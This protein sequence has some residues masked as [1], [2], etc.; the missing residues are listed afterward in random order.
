MRKTLLAAAVGLCFATGAR[1]QVGPGLVVPPAA[2]AVARASADSAMSAATNAHAHAELSYQWATNAWA[3]VVLAAPAW[4]AAT[5][6]ATAITLTN[7]LERPQYL[8]ATGAVSLAFSGLRSPQ[9]FYLIVSG[10][11]SVSFPAETHFVG[12]ATWQT[13][14]QNH[15]L[16]W[17]YG[18]N[19]F[20]NPV[21]T[22]EE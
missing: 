17:Q 21:T 16:V 19:L 6:A 22:S 9:P 12:G 1:A 20:V 13:N 3:G 2:D 7:D 15:F 11:D 8:Y 4:I 14:Q 5:N 10:P 18:T